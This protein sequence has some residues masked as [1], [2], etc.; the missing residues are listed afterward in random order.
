MPRYHNCCSKTIRCDHLSIVSLPNPSGLV[1]S[2]KYLLKKWGVDIDTKRFSCRSVQ[3]MNKR[4][5]VTFKSP[6]NDASNSLSFWKHIGARKYRFLWDT[7]WGETTVPH[8]A[9]CLFVLFEYLRKGDRVL[10]HT[11]QFWVLSDMIDCFEWIHI[12]IHILSRDIIS[13][14]WSWLLVCCTS[15]VDRQP[16]PPN[17]PPTY[18]THPF[19]SFPFVSIAV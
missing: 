6:F 8:G 18:S 13:N 16:S 9:P 5:P 12:H 2:K 1:Q 4:C 15:V 17:H 19:F 11:I 7:I 3:S 14:E 10:L